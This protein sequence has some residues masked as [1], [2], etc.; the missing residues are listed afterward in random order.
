MGYSS[1]R[2]GSSGTT[3]AGRR[4]ASSRPRTIALPGRYRR[5]RAFG[6]ADGQGALRPRPDAYQFGGLF[7]VDGLALFF[8][9][10]AIISTGIVMLLAIDYFKRIDFHRG[11]FY[12]LLIFATLAITSLAASTDLIMIYLS[13]EFLSLTSTSWSDTSSATR[14]RAR[15]RSSTSCFGAVSAAVMLYGMSILYGMTG[16]TNISGITSAFRRRAP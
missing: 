10:I 11:E 8:K 9:P 12:A 2:S 6:H 1:S 3:T 7:A 14:S 4:S 15:R 16:H 5:A 13:L